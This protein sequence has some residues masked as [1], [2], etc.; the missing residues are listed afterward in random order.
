[1]ERFRD[2]CEAVDSVLVQTLKPHEVIV[3]VDHNSELFQRLKGELAPAVTIVHNTNAHGLSETRNVAIRTSRGEIVA[4]IDDDALAAKDWLENLTRDFHNPKVVAVGGRAVPLWL[5]GKRP[6][7]FPEELDWIVGCTYK[8]LPC[9]GNEIRNVPGCNMVF[10]KEV[11]NEAGLWESK[12]G[13]IG[14][15]LKGGEEAELCIRIKNKIPDCLIL[16]EPN[17]IIHH[18]VPHSRANIRW[19][20]KNSFDQGVCKAKIKKLCNNATGQALTTEDS[21]LRYL[22][23]KSIP[24]RL[25]KF[26]EKGSLPQM[27][28]I[29]ISIAATGLGYLIGRRRG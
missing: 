10:A 20:L 12:I 19:V 26:W 27:G 2:T 17:A 16:W 14:Q 25:R 24:E 21:Y 6:Y 8:G 3:A 9:H 11:F 7:W 18:K 28:A 13:S 23:F 5:D 29:I 15:S 4:F 1:M 22:L